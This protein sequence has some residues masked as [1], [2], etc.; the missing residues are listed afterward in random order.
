MKPVQMLALTLLPALALAEGNPIT[1]E[2]GHWTAQ[3]VIH[4]GDSWDHLVAI[5]ETNNGEVVRS[6]FYFAAR[7]ESS[8]P[9]H[10]KWS[11]PAPVEPPKPR[12]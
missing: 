12:K 7:L 8:P 5:V 2:G 1:G 3:G 6:D 4:Y 10:Q 9:Y 11:E